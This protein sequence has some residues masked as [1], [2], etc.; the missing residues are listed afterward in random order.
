MNSVFIGS[1]V[2]YFNCIQMFSDF[3][4][5]IHYGKRLFKENGANGLFGIINIY[6]F[7]AESFEQNSIMM[8]DI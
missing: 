4:M 6:N 2:L 5:T 8:L 1:D 7:L 3:Q